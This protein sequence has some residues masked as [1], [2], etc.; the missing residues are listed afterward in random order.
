MKSF[1]PKETAEGRDPPSGHN[2][3]ADFKG[4]KRSNETHRSKSDPDAKLYR[5]GPGLEAKLCFIGHDL[6]ENRSGLVDARLTRVLGHVQRL[7]ALEMIRHWADRPRPAGLRP[8][9]DWADQASG[10][11]QRRFRLDLRGRRLQPGAHAEADRS[12]T[13]R[14]PDTCEIIGRWR[15]V[16]A[17]LW[18]RNYLDL[19]KPAYLKIGKEGW[20]E[21][22]F[23][24]VQAGGEIEYARTI[25]FFRWKA[26]RSPATPPPSSRKTAPSRSSYPSIMATTP[27]SRRNAREF[28]KSVLSSEPAGERCGFPKPFG[29][30][31]AN[32]LRIL[33]GCAR[34]HVSGSRDPQP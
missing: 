27:P 26:T 19:V 31:T 18:D 22:A 14:G 34:R 13:M 32:R 12:R 28:F 4:E 7:A 29:R 9:P 20:A 11:G 33:M 25:V 1:E 17:D 3:P 21:F 30:G 23:G 2:A 10:L 8:L 16:E 5:K 24:A 6:M 15:I